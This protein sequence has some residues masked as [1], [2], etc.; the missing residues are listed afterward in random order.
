VWHRQDI[1]ALAHGKTCPQLSATRPSGH[2]KGYDE[3][4]NG[5]TYDFKLFLA[6]FSLFL[7][8]FCRKSPCFAESRSFSPEVAES[9]RV[10]PKVTL[11]LWPP[12]AYKLR[13]LMI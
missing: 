10:S 8:L 5:S 1:F 3:A 4:K 2:K 9:R 11:F 7:T 12:I 6:L 13:S